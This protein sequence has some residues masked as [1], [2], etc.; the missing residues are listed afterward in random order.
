M[1]LHSIDGSESPTFTGN[2]RMLAF[3]LGKLA[4]IEAYLALMPVTSEVREHI[5]LCVLNIV[6]TTKKAKLIDPQDGP[7]A[8]IEAV[9]FEQGYLHSI[10]SIF[11][12][13]KN[14]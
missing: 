12:E 9:C 14:K 10:S 3:I 11:P 4:T 13:A 2:D 5:K 8:A 1:S 6:E 7:N